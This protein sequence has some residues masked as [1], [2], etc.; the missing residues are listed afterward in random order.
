MKSF[1]N[2][3]EKVIDFENLYLAYCNSKK[4]K[5]YRMQALEFKKNLEENLIE[6][7]NE[8][9]WQCYTSRGYRQFWINDPKKRLISAPS[10][11]DRVVH[12]ALVQ[13]V[14][15]I[16]ERIFIYDTYACRVG[17]GTHAAVARLQSFT[18]IAKRNYGHY[19]AL[20]CDIS[21]FFPSINH[22]ILKCIFAHYI[23]DTRVRKLYG[24]IIDSYEINGRGLPI[25]ALTSQLSANLY[26][27]PLDHYIKE[28]LHERFYVRYMDDF[29]ILSPSK[30]R[31]RDDLD[32]IKRFLGYY[33][34]M[35]LNPKTSIV[36]DKEGI[37]FCGY[38]IW[39]THIIARKRTVKRMK[40]RLKKLARFYRT[41]PN[42]LPRARQTI[43]SFLGYMQR[44]NGYQTTKSVLHSI[45]FRV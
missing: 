4:G 44:C 10:F 23:R 18:R 15:P 27:S 9:I 2:L 29:I 40:R 34:D 39:P 21:K 12:H 31:L 24:Q 42:I 28:V 1:N 30:K 14:E 43:M 26:L 35:R 45:I 33:L 38:K 16:F 37:D 36:Q 19:Y 22:D 13:V 11:R 17:K 8:L 5:R 7:Q 25:G 3:F 20:K 32:K 41:N 6:I